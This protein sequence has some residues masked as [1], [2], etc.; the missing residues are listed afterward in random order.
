[1]P[2]LKLRRLISGIA[3]WV[4]ELVVLDMGAEEEVQG[5]EEEGGPGERVRGGSWVLWMISGGRSVRVVGDW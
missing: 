2:L 3:L 1:M 4:G 5:L